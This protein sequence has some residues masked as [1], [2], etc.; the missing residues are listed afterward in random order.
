MVVVLVLDAIP[1]PYIIFMEIDM[2]VKTVDIILVTL[3]IL[4]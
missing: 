4:I 3:Q 1:D 2:A